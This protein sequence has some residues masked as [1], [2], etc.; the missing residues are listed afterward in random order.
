MRARPHGIHLCRH[1]GCAGMRKAHSKRIALVAALSA[2]LLALGCGD[3][4]D[5]VNNNA[6][7][8]SGQEAEVAQLVDDFANAGRDGD[9]EKVCN[10]IFSEAL[11]KNVEK[12]AGRSC[13]GEVEDNLPEGD[14]ELKVNA[15]E[16]KGN[17]ATATVTDQEDSKSVLHIQKVGADWRITSVTPG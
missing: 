4:G 15:L 3:D 9:G 13:P 12:A 11:T 16:V 7:D 5:D 8:Y 14:Y 17:T 6:D 1:L 10:E 2:G